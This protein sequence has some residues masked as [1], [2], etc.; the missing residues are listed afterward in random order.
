MATR[1]TTT[2]SDR[3]AIMRAAWASY[4]RFHAMQESIRGPRTFDRNE[5]RFKLQFAWAEVRK[6]QMTATERRKTE[7]KQEIAS[8]AYKPARIDIFPMQ[9]RLEAELSALAA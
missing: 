5:F 3:A 4:R 7:I 9:R 2:S 1:A 8:L 6:A